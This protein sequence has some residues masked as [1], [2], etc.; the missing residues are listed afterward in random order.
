MG[1]FDIGRP[2]VG[3]HEAAVCGDH[4]QRLES[5]EQWLPDTDPPHNGRPVVLMGAD[6]AA[7]ALPVVTAVRL[8]KRMDDHAP[9]LGPYSRLSLDITA[10]GTNQNQTVEVVLSADGYRYL[11]DI[12]KSADPGK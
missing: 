10:F 12:I 5:G 6:I 4:L 3:P 8:T 7:K 1:A 2:G 9:N 11:A